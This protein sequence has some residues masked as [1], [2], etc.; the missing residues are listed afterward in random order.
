LNLCFQYP[1]VR[2]EDIFIAVLEALQLGWMESPHYFGGASETARDVIAK[3]LQIDTGK[4]ARLLPPHV[5]EKYVK[6]PKHKEKTAM[7][8]FKP[9][10][11]SHE[12]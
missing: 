7:M 9:A 12:A 1:T 6:Y 2:G 10:A 8:V 4:H 5:H 11:A 3:N